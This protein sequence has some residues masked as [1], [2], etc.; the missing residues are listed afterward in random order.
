MGWDDCHLHHFTADHPRSG[1]EHCIG[2]PDERS[3]IKTGRGLR[4]KPY[5]ASNDKFTYL[6]DYGDDWL[7]II[8]YEGAFPSQEGITYPICLAGKQACPPE[9]VGGVPGYQHLLEAIMSPEHEDHEELLEW[10]GPHDPNDFD[11]KRIRFP[12]P[13]AHHCW[14]E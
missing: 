13:S 7:H 8:E 10:S 5:L 12:T 6:Y 3:G 14:V 1:S 9:D 11:P 4:V 2:I